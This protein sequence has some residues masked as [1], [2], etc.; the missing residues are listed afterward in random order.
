MGN[1][2]W[3]TTPQHQKTC[4]WK[5]SWRLRTVSN[6]MWVRYLCF[7]VCLLVCLLIDVFAV[8]KEVVI[9]RPNVHITEF[10]YLHIKRDFLVYIWRFAWLFY[11]WSVLN[12]TLECCFDQWWKYHKGFQK[13][14]TSQKTRLHVYNIYLKFYHS[15]EVLCSDL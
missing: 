4:V 5:S 14:A 8:G 9:K 2:S 10:I 3:I 15:L 7:L 1:V 12:V 6:V 11:S 13:C